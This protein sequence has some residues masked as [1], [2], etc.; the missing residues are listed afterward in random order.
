VL[1]SDETLTLSEE[2]LGSMADEAGA[3]MADR[4]ALERLIESS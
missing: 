1:V 3:G 2:R 4:R